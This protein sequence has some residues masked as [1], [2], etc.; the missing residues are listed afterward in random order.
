M[1]LELGSGE[2]GQFFTPSHI[3]DLTA[4]ITISKERVEEELKKTGYVSMYD[5]CVG[6]GSMIIAGAVELRKLGYNYQKQLFVNCGDLDPL[7]CMMC[8][9][10]LSL[11]GIPAKVVQ[12]DTFKLEV[13]DTWYTPF[14]V[15]DRWN[16]RLKHKE[17]IETENKAEEIVNDE[18]K[19][20]LS[21][22]DM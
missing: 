1:R 21:I 6:A 16:Y 15:M 2:I 11:L 17:V 7:A 5:S 20:Q 13:I 14:Y 18:E 4:S 10:H 12:Q 3:S 19:K 8:Y 9:I 22:F